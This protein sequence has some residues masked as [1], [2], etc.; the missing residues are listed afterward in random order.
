VACS[1]L[2]T[3]SMTNCVCVCV[4]VCMRA[5]AL[6]YTSYSTELGQTFGN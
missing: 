4:C 3:K 2:G 5:H 6:S 1:A